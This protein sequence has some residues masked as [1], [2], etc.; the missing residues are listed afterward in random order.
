MKTTRYFFLGLIG[1]FT[2]ISC[3]DQK[4][5]NPRQLSEANANI[6]AVIQRATFQD[7]DGNDVTLADFEGKVLLIDFWETWCGPCLQVFPAMDSLKTEYPDDFE[8][9][10]VNLIDGDTKADVQQFM[11]DND[12][13][14][15]YS[16]DVNDIGDEIITLGIP[17]KVFIDPNG[18]LIKA[19]LGSAGTRG[20]YE[21]AKVI[22]EENKRS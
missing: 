12:Y 19:E 8:V 13:D 18:F 17:F 1:L 3:A 15:V 10:T 6:E 16:M 7:I 11:A 20:D 22:I 5:Q 9:L 4:S 2:M 14:F 21:K